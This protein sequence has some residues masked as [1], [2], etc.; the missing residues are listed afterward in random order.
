MKL[1]VSAFDE[2]KVPEGVEQ[3][4]VKGEILYYM[5]KEEFKAFLEMNYYHTEVEKSEQL[6]GD[7]NYVMISNRVVAQYWESENARQIWLNDN[8]HAW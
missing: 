6:V 2:L 3:D 7:L 5:T 8:I 1:V 4:K